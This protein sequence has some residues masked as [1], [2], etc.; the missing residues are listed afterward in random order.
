[1]LLCKQEVTGSIPVGSIEEC[2]QSARVL[3]RA[4]GLASESVV[5]QCLNLGLTHDRGRCSALN[6]LPGD[7]VSALRFVDMPAHGPL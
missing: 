5:L 6:A 3:L 1:M 7:L 2:L 4:G